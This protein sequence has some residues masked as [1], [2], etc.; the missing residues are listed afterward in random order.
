VS[1]DAEPLLTLAR[2]VVAQARPG[3]S[4]EV[5]A[6]SST[7][8][9]VK[10]YEGGIESLT[11]A[12]TASFGVRV[13]VDHRQGYASAGSH[14]PSLLA[15]LLAEARDNAAYSQPD[16]FAGLADPDDAV[17]VVHD[18]W[19]DAVLATPTSAKIDLAHELEAAV[20]AGDPRITG[21][22]N[23]I[24]GDG[25]GGSVLVASNGIEISEGATWT[26]V[27]V[28][29]LAADDGATQ[30]GYAA[31]V[32]RR[33]DRLDLDKVATDAVQRA[34][35]LLGAQKPA[36]GR[37]AM[38]L[39][40][41]LVATIVGFVAAMCSGERLLKGRTP[42]AGREGEHL[43]SALFTLVD[44]PTDSRSFGASTYD[45]EGLASRRNTL[46]E[47]GEFRGFLHNSYTARRLG[48]RSTASAVRAG[49][50]TPG[51][52]TRALAVAAGSG[53]LEELI[54]GVD[55]GVLVQ[56]FHGLHS[57]V[58]AVSGDFSVG[59]DGLLIRDGALGAP[60]REATVA[61]TLPRMLADIAAVGADLEWLNGGSSAPSVVIDGLALSGT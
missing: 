17:P 61:S 6:S 55:T 53:T 31:D 45:A 44:D 12:T 37:V 58:N 22:R 43:A 13:V 49:A 57:G 5:V 23:A 1:F 42:F 3:E 10:V 34:T 24:Y 51:V 33:P 29:A 47:G 50:G 56:S 4:I 19:H 46:F 25:A 26:S 15:G 11:T 14:D 27:S 2:G 52:G 41:R 21:V 28:S 54:A 60:F 8:T 38:V 35:R 7:G 39:E 20:R 48:T 36:S 16:P 59:V 40:P 9:N 32:A 30:V 18:L